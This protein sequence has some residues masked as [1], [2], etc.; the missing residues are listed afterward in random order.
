[1]DD[2]AD[3]HHAQARLIRLVLVVELGQRLG[4]GFAGPIVERRFGRVRR[5]G[6]RSAGKPEDGCR[7]KARA[8]RD[9]RPGRDRKEVARNY[10]DG[11]ADHSAETGRQR[12]ASRRGKERCEARRRDHAGQIEGDFPARPLK[13]PL[14]DE[15]PAPE[16]GRGQQSR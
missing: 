10:E 14:G 12:P 3:R 15:R 5:A 4:A 8:E 2:G 1:M 13:P 7:G 9:G 11:V 16:R 6:A